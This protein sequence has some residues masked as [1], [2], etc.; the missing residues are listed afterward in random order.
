MKQNE[1]LTKRFAGVNGTIGRS[2]FQ[3]TD[4]PD[5]SAGVVSP[6][7]SAA[8]GF[9]R[10]AFEL[11][12][13]GGGNSV[14]YTVDG[15]SSY[16]SGTRYS[17]PIP[18]FDRSNLPDYYASLGPVSNVYDQFY[19]AEPVSKA[20]VIRAVSQ[21]DDGT[22][23][24]ETVAT[25]FI[26]EEI[27][28]ICDGT[29]TVSMVCDPVDL[30]S[31]DRGIY[32]TG[33]TWELNKDI[34]DPT[35]LHKAPTNYNMRGKGWD[36]NAA[37][38]LFGPDGNLLYGERA[39][40]SIHGCYSRALNPKG[41]NLKPVI[42]EQRIFDGLLEGAGDSLVL[43][44]GSEMDTFKT[45]FRNA[46]NNRIC[47][48]LRIGAQNSVCCQL[49]LNGEY[50]GCYSIIDRL[51]ESFIEARYGVPAQ[52]VDLIKVCSCPKGIRGSEDALLHYRELIDYVSRHDFG[53]EQYY[54][55]FCDMMDID[56]LIDYYCTQIYFANDDAYVNN[57]GLW[58]AQKVSDH[59]YEDG[60]WRYALY[61][62]DNMDGYDESALASVDSFTEGN[63]VN[64][65]PDTELFFSNLSKNADF[66]K[67]FYKRFTELL[68]TDFSYETIAPLLDETEKEYTRPM[69]M[70][71]HRFYDPTYE[72]EWYH[73]SVA[74][75]R[76][77]F[78]ERGNYISKYLS[79]HMGD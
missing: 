62:L 61:D 45:C 38:D 67:R 13:D 16:T 40:I 10:E 19:P 3:E 42:K 70:T 20:M 48:N 56:N 24:G 4:Q 59:P 57:V 26:G 30:F 58:R 18:V 43:R 77:F 68:N 33:S 53:D 76:Q 31:A 72:K 46:L 73:E 14:F 64:I 55:Q 51:D 52:N 32:V 23:S 1:V 49:Y 2:S 8:S 6:T 34:V 21:S 35:M 29:Y 78:M 71:F 7:F 36:R 25:Y 47:R 60:K 22:F 65:N 79:K 66:R 39:S 50:W 9:Y 11:I 69:L 63:W 54:Q 75:V 44:T 41:F 17:G 27:R 5:I 74:V 37:L 28:S 15:S 12:I